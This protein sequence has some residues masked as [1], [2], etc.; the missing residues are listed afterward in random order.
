[1]SGGEQNTS[2]G[3]PEPSGE[4]TKVSSSL[5]VIGGMLIWEA[6]KKLASAF[7]RKGPEITAP[8]PD[9]IGVENASM[10]PSRASDVSLDSGKDLASRR[11]WGTF[12]GV[13]LCLA[14]LGGGVGFLV[15]YWTGGSNEALGGF[16]F[17]FFAGLALGLVVNAH[18]LADH[19]E[20]TEPREALLP[21]PEERAAVEEDFRCGKLELQRRGL[22]KWMAVVGLGSVGAIFISLLRSIM[23]DPFTTL[24]S[25]VWVRGQRLMTID[26]KPMKADSLPPGGTAIVFPEDRIGDERSQ[27]VLIRVNQQLLE[28]PTGRAEWAPQGNLA[29][30][31]ICTHAGCPV[32]M[33][34]KTAHLLM[35]PCHQSTFDVLR[36]AQP[37]GGPAARSLPQ[38]PL[39]VDSDGVLR[40]GGDFSQPPGPGFWGMP[41]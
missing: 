10:S 16:L 36:A 33:Y 24:F 41:S 27:T 23:P 2:G 37:T 1:M 5:L 9:Q 32:G 15:I 13:C 40:A 35:C 39:Y 26:G 38:L 19:K 25:R 8:G 6:G 7:L 12:L 30:S 20:A 17:I 4:S 18:L 34:E 29:F 21:P 14:A 3:E 28:L 22:L 11:R 31:R